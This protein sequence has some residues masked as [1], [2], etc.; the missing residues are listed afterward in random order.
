MK[1]I[2][3][4][5]YEYPP[6]GGGAGI[7]ATQL[8][9]AGLED[10]ESKV[11]TIF[12]APETNLFKSFF[13][14][15]FFYKR[16]KKKLSN[17]NYDLILLNDN[18]AIL[19]A[20]K[21][22]SSE[23]LHTCKCIVHGFDYLKYQNEN[24]RLIDRVRR[25]P[26][27]YYRAL[28][29]SRKVICVSKYVCKRIK[30]LERVKNKEN[31]I[32]SYCGLPPKLIQLYKLV[33][34]RCFNSDFQCITLLSISRIA[35]SKGYYKKVLIFKRLVDSG[36][37]LKW[38]VVGDGPYLSDLKSLINDFNLNDRVFFHGAMP[39]YKFEALFRDSDIFWL[40]PIAPEAFGLVY[41]E[42]QLSGMSAIGSHSGGISEAINLETGLVSDDE[43]A[44]SSYIKNYRKSLLDMESNFH[45][46]SKFNCVSFYMDIT[47][48]N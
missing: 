19:C 46:S 32:T 41:I 26:V 38:N 9:A 40:L 6:N 39:R 36:Y 21:Y 20:G 33:S 18:R 31:V 15:Y 22:F 14:D 30:E 2:L 45:F 24:A 44:I 43:D 17:N 16:I 3:L 11:D 37:D 1:S 12:G 42:A 34:R 27:A 5:S 28:N 10:D 25:F 47:S 7:V 48:D 23:L 29:F 13:F 35:K 4:V 8:E